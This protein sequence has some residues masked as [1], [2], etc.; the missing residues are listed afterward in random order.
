MKL[1]VFS[2]NEV[3]WINF[4]FSPNQK[5]DFSFPNFCRILQ[6][7]ICRNFRIDRLDFANKIRETVATFDHNL[8]WK[9]EQMY[10]NWMLLKILHFIFIRIVCL[11]MEN[12]ML[13]FER[14][15]KAW[16]MHWTMNGQA[17]VDFQ[18]LWNYILFL[19][20]GIM[21]MHCSTAYGFVSFRFILSKLEGALDDIAPKCIEF[22][23]LKIACVCLYTGV[24]ARVSV[25][26]RQ[27]HLHFKW[28]NWPASNWTMCLLHIHTSTRLSSALLI[29]SNDWHEKWL[30]VVDGV[31]GC[32]PNDTI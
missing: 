2:S 30:G 26:G 12:T 24:S 29:R 9:M 4:S 25:C 18:T 27:L 14:N 7:W 22:W 10:C 11:P 32:L 3:I 17:I 20:C 21:H 28:M 5:H 23:S 19:R 16:R 31:A 6:R 1:S 13:I 8:C 15:E